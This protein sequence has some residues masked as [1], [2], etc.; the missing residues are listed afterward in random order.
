MK[1]WILFYRSF[2]AIRRPLKLSRKVPSRAFYFRSLLPIL[3][4]LTERE[5]HISRKDTLEMA[6]NPSASLPWPC[7]PWKESIAY[8]ALSST[9]ISKSSWSLGRL[10]RELCCLVFN[11]CV[12]L[13]LIEAIACRWRPIFCISAASR[14]IIFAC[15]ENWSLSTVRSPI[16]SSRSLLKSSFVALPG[17]SKW[18]YSGSSLMLVLVCTIALSIS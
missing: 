16:L 4:R 3:L 15:V 2:I 6:F 17:N 7:M 14:S 8:T 12:S 11:E 18:N 1:L 9:I 10:S 5:L 13:R